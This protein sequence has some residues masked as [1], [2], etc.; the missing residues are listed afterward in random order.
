MLM[1]EL[2]DQIKAGAK[3]DRKGRDDFPFVLQVIAVKPSRLAAR[4]EYR[5]GHVGGLHAHVVHRKNIGSGLERRPLALDV[6]TAAQGVLGRNFPAAVSLCAGGDAAPIGGLA[7]AGKED[8][9]GRVTG[10]KI[11]AAEPVECR[12]LEI[13]WSGAL[14]QCDDGEI[15]VLK[16]VLVES[17]RREIGDAVNGKPE[18]RSEVRDIRDL[19]LAARG[20]EDG[21]YS[22]IRV[23]D[24]GDIGEAARLIGEVVDRVFAARRILDPDVVVQIF[25]GHV[26]IDLSDDTAEFD[27]RLKPLLL[28]AI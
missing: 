7:D 11:H 8:G 26:I 28:A 20:A 13:D 1:C 4:I 25:S 24:A 12:D 22:R 16:L 17:R 3:I 6:K 18:T 10:R 21:A 23:D 19:E 2:V 14:L 15:I 9:P 27:A 5:E